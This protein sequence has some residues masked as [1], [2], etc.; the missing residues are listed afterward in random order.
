MTAESLSV[1][2][3][4][5]NAD[6]A[7]MVERVLSHAAVR[8]SVSWVTTLSDALAWMATH[9][10]DVALVDLALPDSSGMDTVTRIRCN[11]LNVPVVLLTVNACEDTANEA[12]LLGAQDYLVKD[13]LLGTARTELLERAIRYAIHR[14]KSSETRDL[15]QQIE[16]SHQ[17][18]ETKNCRLAGCRSVGSR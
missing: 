14:Q 7:A 18:L 15:L 13:W 4:E 16:A 1:L 9:R 5:D 3:V 2:L 12:L 11:K 8:Y 6:D 17:L 10:I